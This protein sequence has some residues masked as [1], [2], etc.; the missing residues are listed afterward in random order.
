MPTLSCL[1]SEVCMAKENTAE[2]IDRLLRPTVEGLGYTLWDVEFVREG[3]DRILRLTIDAENGVGLNDCET[4]SRAVDPVLDEADPIECAYSLQVSS[5]GLERDLKT[6]FHYLSCLGQEAE[7]K[8]FAP[9]DGKKSLK[10]K[11]IAFDDG[12]ITL[13]IGGQPLT[14]EIGAV[15]KGKTVFE[16]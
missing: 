12:K 3:S 6:P 14:V 11:L 13:E 7:L 16:F 10:G 4:V 2:K 5:P 15:S 1:Y 9:L 8:L